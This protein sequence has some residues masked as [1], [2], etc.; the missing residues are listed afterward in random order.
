MLLSRDKEVFPNSSKT[1][2]YNNSYIYIYIYI[3]HKELSY[4]DEINLFRDL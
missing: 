3:I 4:S 2:Y 1:A